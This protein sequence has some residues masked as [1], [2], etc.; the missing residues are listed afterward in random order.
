MNPCVSRFEGQ[1]GCSGTGKIN[2]KSFS[3]LRKDERKMWHCNYSFNQLADCKIFCFEKVVPSHCR[4]QLLLEVLLGC[5]RFCAFLKQLEET[6]VL[7]NKCILA[8][9]K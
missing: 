2:A 7:N 6:E 3:K 4:Q 8:T 9:A 1:F 5:Q